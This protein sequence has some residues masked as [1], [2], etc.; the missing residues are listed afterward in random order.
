MDR[1]EKWFVLVS[2]MYLLIGSFLGVIM[3][4]YST[5][6][7]GLEYYLIPSHTHI[8]LLG[9]MSMMIF[10][11]A[12]H[13]LPRFSGRLLYSRKLAWVHF[14]LSQVGLVGMALFFFLNRLQEGEWK[15]WLML[16]GMLMFLS[17][18]L[19]VFNMLKTLC[20]PQAL[21]QRN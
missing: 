3:V 19:F 17:I 21:S 1:F 14:V 2:L 20:S 18:M 5:E 12:Y 10:G 6:W 8:N 4:T 13:V 16:S 9:W 15:N 11:V 7:K